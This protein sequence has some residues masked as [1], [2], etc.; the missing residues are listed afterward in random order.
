MILH[1]QRHKAN[2]LWICKQVDKVSLPKFVT[3]YVKSGDIFGMLR[4]KKK[5][6]N[7]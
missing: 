5:Y 6:F 7:E 2:A 1:K 3:V 4:F